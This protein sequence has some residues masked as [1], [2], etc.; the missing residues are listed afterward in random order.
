MKTT[1]KIRL[2]GW[3]VGVDN[4]REMRDS[5]I[6]IPPP[7]SVREEMPASLVF[8][9]FV[10]FLVPK[11]Q[12]DSQVRNKISKPRPERNCLVWLLG[13]QCII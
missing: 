7:P 1:T 4:T 5:A 12:S 2:D 6:P 9:L 11:R 13:K 10:C 8:I 3:W